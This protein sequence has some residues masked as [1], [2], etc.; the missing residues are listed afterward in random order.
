MT[1]EGRDG[2]DRS[3]RSLEATQER[4]VTGETDLIEF[5]NQLEHAL[6]R[7]QCRASHDL[8]V[9]LGFGPVPTAIDSAGSSEPLSSRITRTD[10]VFLVTT[11]VYI[12]A[13]GMTILEL[14]TVSAFPTILILIFVL[15]TV[16]MVFTAEHTSR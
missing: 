15:L 13:A 7:E 1:D 4:Y 9:D 6:E 12:L 14:V 2:C 16:V 10:V 8:D 3:G 11:I 5:E